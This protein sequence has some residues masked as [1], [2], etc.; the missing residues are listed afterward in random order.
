[1]KKHWKLFLS[2]FI[3]SLFWFRPALALEKINNYQ[4]IVQL[5]ADNT[6]TVTERID[7]D[8]GDAQRH[9]I[10]R[11]IP[12]LYNNFLWSRAAEI[13][14]ISVADENGQ[15]Y[16]FVVSN[17]NKD[18]QIKIG[19][20]DVYVTGQKIYVIKYK[21]SDP[22]LFRQDSDQFYWDIIG[23]GWQ[24][25]ISQS[26]V[27]IW[28]PQ[29]ISTGDLEADCYAG[30]Y[31]SNSSCNSIKY[32]YA[33]D[34]STLVSGLVLKQDD[35]SAGGILTVLIG[36]P[37]GAI[38]EPGFWH[39]TWQIF[40]YNGIIFLP[41]LAFI[42]AF[43]LW[44]KRGRDPKGRGNIIA[45]YDV[46]DKLS[47]GEVAV[48][49]NEKIS[50]QDISAEVIYLAINGYLKITRLEKSGLIKKSSDYLLEKFKD[51]KDLPN[52]FQKDLLA[53]LFHRASSPDKLKGY[54]L[55]PR[56][57]VA[58]LLSDLDKAYEWRPIVDNKLLQSVA[59]KGYFIKNPNKI[60]GIYITVF[61]L[62]LLPIVI[63]LGLLGIFTPLARIALALSMII[64]IIF[65]WQ[66]PKKT[67]K[68]ALTK[69]YILGLKEYLRVAEKD[70]IKF[71]NAPEKNPQHFEALLPY[72]MVLGVEKEWAKQF[73]G[74]Y[75]ENPSWCAGFYVG[76][77][78]S[79]DF[80]HSLENFGAQAKATFATPSSSGGGFAGGGGG[81][82]GGGSW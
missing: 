38:M 53:N 26:T 67:P 75:R 64:L 69:E 58:V 74:I 16:N 1:M 50:N 23:G 36:L 48:V 4:A 57:T 81:G 39:K 10:Y 32:L 78:S 29:S 82:G 49:V 6:M 25:P 45:E 43:I 55:D 9:G 28:L 17:H 62:C 3:L 68:G 65:G 80:S 51:E 52:E 21:V 31:G 19:K 2:A 15:A 41:L 37:K 22:Y 30:N 44:F 18:K 54:Q 7:Y 61:L 11:N 5:N 47:P 79:A 77:F 12:Y 46:P 72:A 27:T 71:H 56:T 40:K 35:L 20:A 76:T 66:M 60:R 73:E 59:D 63:V 33:D 24:V 70:R 13:S 8:F 34:G 42:I 14:Q